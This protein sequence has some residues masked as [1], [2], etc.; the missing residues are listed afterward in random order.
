MLLKINFNKGTNLSWSRCDMVTFSSLLVICAKNIRHYDD[1]IMGAIASQITSLTIV[2]TTVYSDADHRKHQSSVS[3]AF[4]RGIHRRPVNSPH[5]GPVTWK[6][7]PFDDVIMI[8]W[9]FP[10]TWAIDTELLWLRC[11]YPRWAFEQTVGWPVMQ[12]RSCSFIVLRH[13]RI[14][15]WEKLFNWTHN[16]A[17]T[18]PRNINNIMSDKGLA[19]WIYCVK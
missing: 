10:G 7:F 8:Y 5:K 2:Y 9:W 6:M 15:I 11:C 18:R 19:I 13:S 4:V 16:E 12:W 17:I 3:L 1:V 14:V